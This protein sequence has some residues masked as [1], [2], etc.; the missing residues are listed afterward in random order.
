M[1]EVGTVNIGD[2]SIYHIKMSDFGG[3]KESKKRRPKRRSGKNKIFTQIQNLFA[4]GA[5]GSQ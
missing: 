4:T 1:P 2:Q 5:Q 3:I